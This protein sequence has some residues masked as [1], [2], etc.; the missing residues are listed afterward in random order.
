[1]VF[2]FLLPHHSVA[3]SSSA[4]SCFANS[5]EDWA[6]FHDHAL[7][8]KEKFMVDSVSPLLKATD[9]FS[10]DFGCNNYKPVCNVR[11]VWSSL[12]GSY[13]ADLQ[14][15]PFGP[16]GG[17]CEHGINYA[18]TRKVFMRTWLAHPQFEFTLPLGRIEVKIQNMTNGEIKLH[19]VYDL[20]GQ[21]VLSRLTQPESGPH[22]YFFPNW[23]GEKDYLKN[24]AN[25]YKLTVRNLDTKLLPQMDVV[26]EMHF[27]RFGKNQVEASYGTN[28]TW[29]TLQGWVNGVVANHREEFAEYGNS[30]MPPGAPPLKL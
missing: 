15:Y 20:K 12:K 19:A 27:T 13:G 30:L 26:A 5:L 4:A 14:N 2:D 9:L 7:L 22:P 25:S 24:T 8:R 10:T 28:P 21:K 23:C 11:S 18:E 3:A 16:P 29:P 17:G 6:R 1:M